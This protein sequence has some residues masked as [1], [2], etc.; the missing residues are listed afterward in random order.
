MLHIKY[1]SGLT[2]S[3]KLENKKIKHPNLRNKRLKF[4]SNENREIKNIFKL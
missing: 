4:K 1:G 3:N 2:K